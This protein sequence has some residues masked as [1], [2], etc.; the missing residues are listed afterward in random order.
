MAKPFN[1]DDYRLTWICVQ[2]VVDTA[3]LIMLDGEHGSVPGLNNSNPYILGSVAGIG[4]VVIMLPDSD[5]DGLVLNHMRA[6]FPKLEMAVLVTTGGNIP[7]IGRDSR[8]QFGDVVVTHSSSVSEELR[9]PSKALMDAI[10]NSNNFQR[11]LLREHIERIDTEVPYLRIYRNPNAE[12]SDDE[13]RA[14][15]HRSTRD[16][17]KVSAKNSE[18]QDPLPNHESWPC[19]N[20]VVKQLA[21][22]SS[23]IVQGISGDCQSK[24]NNGWLGYPAATAAAYVR[25]LSIYISASI[26]E[27]S[28]SV[29]STSN[30]ITESPC[31]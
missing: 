15:I 31:D 13:S 16:F 12:N 27:E 6:T 3:I 18:A 11:S 23:A 21:N 25:Q 29:F 9:M 19:G 28:R 26:Q 7:D 20:E 17:R 8:I 22:L 30:P 1:P 24:N 2:E 4:V 14:I 10:Q 5:T